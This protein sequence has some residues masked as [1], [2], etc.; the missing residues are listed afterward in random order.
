MTEQSARAAEEAAEVA[1]SEG[2]SSESLQEAD[3]A[4]FEDGH[5][6]ELQREED[7]AREKGDFARDAL[8]R[9]RL[10]EAVFRKHLGFN[11]RCE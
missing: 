11:R 5:A 6:A 9:A 3:M 8:P 1:D 4:R 10:N 7:V 2:Y